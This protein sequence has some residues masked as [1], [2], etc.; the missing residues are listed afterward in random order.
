[1]LKKLL[2]SLFILGVV[3]NLSFAGVVRAATDA[4]IMEKFKKSFPW[5]NAESLRKSDVE[6]MYEVVVPGRVIYYFP[7]KEYILVGS[8]LT[9]SRKNLTEER[10]SE[11][12]TE[13]IKTL[14]LEKGLKIG[15]GKN[16]V[17]EFTDPDCPYCRDASK[18]LSGQGNIAKYV[19]F[20]PLPMHPDAEAKV[21]Y[22][23]CAKDKEKAYEEA[24]T[25]KLD[26]KKYEVCSDEKVEKL[27]SEHKQIA[28]KMGVNSTPQFWIN[29]K[30]VSGANIPLMQSLLG[31]DAKKPQGK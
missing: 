18:F 9:P 13:K 24:M 19:F 3:L 4:E 25:G 14:P 21:R 31:Q 16:V 12:A 28:A 10:M 6:G 30:H 20:I 7:E 26:G 11:I 29:G 15:S 8:I 23:F 2:C 22:V 5:T 27:I 1:M 17:I